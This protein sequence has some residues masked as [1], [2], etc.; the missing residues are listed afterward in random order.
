MVN[1]CHFE[2]ILSFNVLLNVSQVQNS[3]PWEG[4][5]KSDPRMSSFLCFSWS[6]HT[7]YV[8]S[9][10]HKGCCN[11]LWSIRNNNKSELTN[12]WQIQELGKE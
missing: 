10:I 1:T 7:K 5:S 6:R 11:G 12:M 3:A 8:E 9:E 2:S 4:T